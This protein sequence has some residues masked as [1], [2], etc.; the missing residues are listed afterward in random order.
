MGRLVRWVNCAMSTSQERR[1]FGRAPFHARVTVSLPTRQAS[2]EA[3]V[4]DISLGG[5]SLI[6]WERVSDGEDALLTFQIRTRTAKQT[7]EVWSRVIHVRMD[8]DVWVVGL[9]F[10]KVLDRQSTPLLAHA[11]TRR[12]PKLLLD[13]HASL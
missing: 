9:K 13:T 12:N 4:L 2:V 5:V 3:N 1:Q 10:N 6:C 8:D 11:A 7:E